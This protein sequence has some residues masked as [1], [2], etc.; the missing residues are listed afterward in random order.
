MIK[1]LIIL[2]KIMVTVVMAV[3]MTVM[4]TVMIIM[5]SVTLNQTSGTFRDQPNSRGAFLSSDCLDK[6]E[7]V[8]LG[9]ITVRL[10]NFTLSLFNFLVFK[11]SLLLPSLTFQYNCYIDFT[12]FSASL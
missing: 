7:Q 3:M 2:T 1:I 11:S 10:N 5:R 12:L 9:C 8:L 4:V 6:P